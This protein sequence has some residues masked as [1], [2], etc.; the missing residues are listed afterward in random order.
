MAGMADTVLRGTEQVL[1]ARRGVSNALGVLGQHNARERD[2]REERTRRA[3]DAVDKFATFQNE[4]RAED[5]Q[6]GLADAF[7]AGMSSGDEKAAWQALAAAPSTTREGAKLKVDL[8]LKVMDIAQK[9]RA[10]EHQRLADEK[11]TRALELEEA[12]REAV[13][14]A[15]EPIETLNDGSGIDLEMDL[16]GGDPKVSPMRVLRNPTED[17]IVQR[18]AAA[19]QLGPDDLM[20]HLQKQIPLDVADKQAASR[21]A[22]AAANAASKIELQK[23]E[24]VLRAAQIKQRAEEARATAKATFESKRPLMERQVAAQ[25]IVAKASVGRA[26]ASE[27]DALVRSAKE[28]FDQKR[29]IQQYELDKAEELLQTTTQNL[30][31]LRKLGMSKVS[32]LV[33]GGMDPED[34]LNDPEV[35]EAAKDLAAAIKSSKDLRDKLERLK[36]PDEV[37]IK[38]AVK[39][40]AAL[41]AEFDALTDDQK[42]AFLKKASPETRAKVGR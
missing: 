17:E 26:S 40:D 38:S 29:D 2:L 30:E 19:K 9:R 10:A 20:K 7:M 24:G 18:L 4:K 15:F 34:A 25:E 41:K 42:K 8:G 23:A 32:T 28:E 16:L 11:I 5:E 36:A 1:G 13:S 12:G 27:I 21:E 3:F 31:F 37:G 6:K 14:K 35:V 33:D 39:V 22:I